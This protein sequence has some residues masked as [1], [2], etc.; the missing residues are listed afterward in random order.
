MTQDRIYPKLASR[1]SVHGDHFP[2]IDCL[3]YRTYRKYTVIFLGKSCQIS[4]RYLKL[5]TQR[6]FALSIDAVANRTT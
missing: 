4:R 1:D 3:V 6:S 5:L 2:P